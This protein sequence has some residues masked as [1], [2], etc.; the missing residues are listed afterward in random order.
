MIWSPA[1]DEI[2]AVLLNARKVANHARE[3]GV[4]DLQPASRPHGHHIGAVLADAILQAG[5]NY[6]TVVLPRVQLIVER[7]PEAHQLDGVQ[8]III[9]GGIS[10]FLKWKHHTKLTRFASLVSF[11][12]EQDIQCVPQLRERLCSSSFRESLLDL[13]GIGPK[14]IDYLSCLTGIDSVAVDR[15]IRS[16][17]RHSGVDADDYKGLH[18]VFSCAADLL[19]L[20]RRDLDSWVWMRVS[21]SPENNDAAETRSRPE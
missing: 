9:T 19:A 14:T 18:M 11:L 8:H 21:G 17:A 16:F 5:L 10:D 20:P 3:L 1:A 13:Y 7:Y 2:F 12:A 15:H 4:M 6:R